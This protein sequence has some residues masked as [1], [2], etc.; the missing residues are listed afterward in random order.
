MVRMYTSPPKFSQLPSAIRE[1]VPVYRLQEDCY[2]DDTLW[3][4]G[5]VLETLPDFEPNLAM[6]PLNKVAYDKK[7]EFLRI[8]D[9]K[10]EEWSVKEKKAYVQKLPAFLRQWENINGIAKSKRLSLVQ[11]AGTTPPILGAPL[12]KVN[13]VQVDM[14]SMPQVPF[15][16]GTA[17]GKGNT[18]DRDMSS[19]A[20]VRASLP[21]A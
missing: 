6:F 19:A 8:Y 5:A 11:A 14:T 16:D 17:I 21:K 12:A 10:G 9:E 1:D 3:L 20:A 4:A 15:E 13:V 7:I 2:F 18:M